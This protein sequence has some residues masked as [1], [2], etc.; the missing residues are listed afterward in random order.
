MYFNEAGFQEYCLAGETYYK[1]NIQNTFCMRP[2]I[3][4]F[5]NIY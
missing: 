3:N 5:G 2:K 1:Y 4:N